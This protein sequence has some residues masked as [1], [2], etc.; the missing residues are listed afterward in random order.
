MTGQ[1]QRDKEMMILTDV[2]NLLVPPVDDLPGAGSMG[3]AAEV[4]SLASRHRPYEHALS[5]FT[6]KLEM[7][8]SAQ[9]RDSQKR[10]LLQDL[11]AAD[12]TTFSA[13]LELVYLA[14]YGDPR[15][16]R[17]VGWRG[18]PLQPEGFPLAPFNLESLHTIHQRRPFWRQT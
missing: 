12:G 5:I 2:M 16:Q 14:Y 3:L 13:A 1:T 9:L 6:Q 8:W 15:V 18:G 17:R 10:A 7:K 4:V 11:E